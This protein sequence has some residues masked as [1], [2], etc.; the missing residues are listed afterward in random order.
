MTTQRLILTAVALLAVTSL[1][2]ANDDL[3][4]PADE[5]VYCTVCHGVQLMG[6]AVLQAPR[7]SGMESWYVENQLKAYKKGWRGKHTDDVIGMEMRPMAVL[8]DDQ[9]REVAE[10]VSNTRS[11]LPPRSI[12]GDAEKGRRH[13]STCAA[14]HG[15]RAEGN[16]ALASPA[17]TGLEDWYLVMQLRNFRN[18]IRGS[19]AG[20]TYGM[21]MRASVGLLADEEAIRDV[22][23]Y[24]STLRDQ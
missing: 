10:Y 5:Y 18:G 20:D 11:D 7:L 15:V 21:Q 24:I 8:S 19:Q 22:V 13:Y 9:I 17:L 3:P 1:A 12:D 4:I 6:N 14:C 16:V 23:A 2:A